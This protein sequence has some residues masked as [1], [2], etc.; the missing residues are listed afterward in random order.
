MIQRIGISSRDSDIV[1]H[2]GVAYFA[3][4]PSHPYD[5]DL[6]TAEQAVQA[7]ESLDEELARLGA[8]RADVLFVTIVLPDMSARDA[9]NALWDDWIDPAAPPARACISAGLAHPDMKVELIVQVAV[10][11]PVEGD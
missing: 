8:V 1:I 6:T 3:I 2:N 4:V 11:N 10:R 5:P 7:L 9:F